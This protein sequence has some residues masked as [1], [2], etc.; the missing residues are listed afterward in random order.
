MF[1]RDRGQRVMIDIAH[2]FSNFFTCFTVVPGREN[3]PVD[4]TPGAPNHMINASN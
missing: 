2:Q 1:G 3:S 4:F